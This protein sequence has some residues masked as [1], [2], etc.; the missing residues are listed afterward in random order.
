MDIEKTFGE[1][2]KALRENKGLPLR[3][4]A[5][6]LDMDQSTLSKIERGERLANSSLIPKI[7]KVFN[8]TEKSLK[9]ILL[10]DQV[11]YQIME[12]NNTHEILKVAEQ[13][14]KYH[15]A[16]KQYGKYQF[17]NKKN[18]LKSRSIEL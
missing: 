4:I 5:A 8:V 15:R 12:E 18:V 16:Q 10:S 3:K 1:H 14:I 17:Q 9:L 2:M 13:K 11:A 6:E 7:A